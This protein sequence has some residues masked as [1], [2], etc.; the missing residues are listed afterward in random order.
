MDY[1]KFEKFPHLYILLERGD[2]WIESGAFVGQAADGVI[3][4]L[5]TVESIRGVG[6]PSQVESYLEKFPSPSC[7]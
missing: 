5:G 3:V 2:M 4:H 6:G 1:S 7:W